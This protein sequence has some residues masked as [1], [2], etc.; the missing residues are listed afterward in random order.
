MRIQISCGGP[1]DNSPFGIKSHSN[2]HVLHAW[3]KLCDLQ[4]QPAAGVIQLAAFAL[5]ALKISCVSSL[6]PSS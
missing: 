4:L 2:F 6:L 1:Y 3:Q 5:R